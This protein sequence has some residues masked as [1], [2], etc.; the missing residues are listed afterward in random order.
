MPEVEPD[1][2]RDVDEAD[3]AEA[4]P[5]GLRGDGG[6]GQ[7]VGAAPREPTIT[8]AAALELQLEVCSNGA[9]S[10]RSSTAGGEPE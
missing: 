3:A 10:L 4:G 8:V 5:A 1:V 2:P 7:H 6:Q 9:G